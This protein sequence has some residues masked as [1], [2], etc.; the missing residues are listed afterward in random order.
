MLRFVII[1]IIINIS[2]GVVIINIQSNNNNKKNPC[3]YFSVNIIYFVSHISVCTVILSAALFVD[4]DQL[5]ENDRLAGKRKRKK[6]REG[7]KK[8]KKNTE[9]LTKEICQNINTAGTTKNVTLNCGGF[10]IA[11]A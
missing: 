10:W 2:N 11:R 8:Q 5:P 1:I 4:S 7:K 6:E 9:V 3:V